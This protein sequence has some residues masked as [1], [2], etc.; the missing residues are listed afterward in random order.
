MIGTI[1]KLFSNLPPSYSLPSREGGLTFYSFSKQK[2]RRYIALSEPWCMCTDE[3][4]CTY[5]QVR[6]PQLGKVGIAILPFVR[7]GLG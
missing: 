7:E 5:K 2:T 6:A 3:V 1:W 4:P